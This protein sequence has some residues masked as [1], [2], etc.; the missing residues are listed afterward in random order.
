[1]SRAYKFNNPESAYFISFA[2]VNWIDVFTRPEYCHILIDSLRY[3]QANKGLQLYAWCIMPSH[4]HLIMASQTEPLEAIL[5]DFKKFTA[6]KIL[7]TIEAHPGESRKAWMLWMFER[8][9][10]RNPNNTRYQF[11]QQ[12]NQ[13]ISLYSASVFEQKL[14][15]LHQNPVKAELVALPEHWH[16]SSARNYADPCIIGPLELSFVR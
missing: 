6:N 4:V 12:H 14:E 1:M 15:Y 10:K 11:W 13:P 5:R 16:W 9:G 8:A 7:Q 3:C 2:T